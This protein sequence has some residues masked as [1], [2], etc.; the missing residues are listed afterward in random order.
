[1]SVRNL[2]MV[3]VK[4]CEKCDYSAEFY[5]TICCDYIGIVH[6]A[7]PK[8]GA[9]QCTA[10]TPKSDRKRAASPYE[11]MGVTYGECEPW[12]KEGVD[13]KQKVPEV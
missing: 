13:D 5:N 11:I 12:R 9:G 2:T 3:D 4:L 1:M 10:F 7:R 8:S 6:R